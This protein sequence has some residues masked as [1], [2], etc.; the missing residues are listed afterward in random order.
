MT[1]SGP[2]CNYGN[3]PLDVVFRLGIRFASFILFGGFLFLLVNAGRMNG[4]RNCRRRSAERIMEIPFSF[5]AGMNDVLDGARRLFCCFFLALV[6]FCFVV[7]IFMIHTGR[8]GN[9]GPASTRT[10]RFLS[11][12]STLCLRCGSG[13]N[14][15]PH[16]GQRRPENPQHPPGRP[17]SEESRTARRETNRY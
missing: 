12:F 6:L 7:E 9:A 2:P 14:R 15:W 17:A 3:R 10:R 1:S 13:R 8:H 5:G 16:S 11:E 4:A